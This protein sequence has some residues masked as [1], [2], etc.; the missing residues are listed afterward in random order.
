MW[1]IF[2]KDKK[3]YWFASGE[4]LKGPQAEEEV[5]KMRSS[6]SREEFEQQQP[7]CVPLFSR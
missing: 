2:R 7:H 6:M 3:G 4:P 5:R 1:Q